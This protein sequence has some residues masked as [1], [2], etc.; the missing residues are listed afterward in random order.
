[1]PCPSQTSG[2]NVPNYIRVKGC[3]RRD[4]IRNEDIRKELNIYNI[5]EKVEDYKEK[6]KEHLSRMDNERI[7]ALI[8]QYQPKGKRDVGRPRKRLAALVQAQDEGGLPNIG[9][10]RSAEV[11]DYPTLR[12]GVGSSLAWANY[13]VEFFRGCPQSEGEYQKDGENPHL[14]C[15]ITV[16]FFTYNYLWVVRKIKQGEKVEYKKK[17]DKTRRRRRRQEDEDEGKGKEAKTRRKRAF[18]LRRNPGHGRRT[19]DRPVCIAGKPS[20]VVRRQACER[21]SLSRRKSQ[22]CCATRH[23]NSEEK[24]ELAE[25][26]AETKL[27]TEGCNERHGEREKSSG[28]KNIV[29]ERRKN[30]LRRRDLNPGFQLYVLMLYPLS[31][32]GYN[33]GVEQNRLILSS[34]SWVPSS[35]RPLHYVIDV[36]RRGCIRSASGFERASDRARGRRSKLRGALWGGARRREER[37]GETTTRWAAAERGKKR[38]SENKSLEAETSRVVFSGKCGL[39]NK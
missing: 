14:L 21:A 20:G 39:T 26:V 8:Q 6:W 18:N 25:S 23:A 17:N 37:R 36:R 19:G 24:K 28:Q 16:Y 2:F 27:P 35:G 4:L 31:H 33:P 22:R 10:A 30:S 7:P 29:M 38:S 5:N 9:V 13:L 3:T 11:L 34:N 1:M 32:T 15:F 12:S